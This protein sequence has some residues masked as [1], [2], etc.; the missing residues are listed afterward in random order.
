MRSV[1][2]TCASVASAGWQQVKRSS[3]RSSWKVVSSISSST[4]SAISSW[5]VLSASVRS[6]RIRSIARRLAVVISQT[7]GADGMPSFGQRSAATAKAS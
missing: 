5:R 4:A 1:S 3:S 7:P 6:R 2:A